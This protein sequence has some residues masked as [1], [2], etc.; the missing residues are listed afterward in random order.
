M[1]Y[2]RGTSYGYDQLQ[3]SPLLNNFD[4][5]YLEVPRILRDQ[6]YAAS[7]VRSNDIVPAPDNVGHY[8]QYSPVARKSRVPLDTRQIIIQQAAKKDKGMANLADV[9]VNQNSMLLVFIFILILIVVINTMTLKQLN[10]QIDHLY[11]KTRSLQSA[12]NN[13]SGS[14]APAVT[15]PTVPP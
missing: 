9:D 5:P 2:N 7:A 11:C 13:K 6:Q 1:D 14:T 12:I 15:T 8:D 3:T 10:K 4:N